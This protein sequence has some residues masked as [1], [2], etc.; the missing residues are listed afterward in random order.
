[1]YVREA[2]QDADVEGQRVN[3]SRF[4]PSL[5]WLNPNAVADRLGSQRAAG[6]KGADPNPAPGLHGHSLTSVA[7]GSKA[8]E[9]GGVINR[10]AS[11]PAPSFTVKL[12]NGGDSD[13]REVVVTARVSGGSGKAP[14]RKKTIGQTKSKDDATVTIP[15]GSSP[16]AGA[17]TLTV[18]VGKVPGEEETANNKQTYTILFT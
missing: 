9:P 6:G 12:A 17:A 10:V 16:P 1:P 15:L 18:T 4:L 8:L 13:E 5:G 11:R 2:L 7:V 3:I 14:P